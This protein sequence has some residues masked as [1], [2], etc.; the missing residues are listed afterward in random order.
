MLMGFF[1]FLK[2]KKKCDGHEYDKQKD[3]KKMSK[4]L[5]TFNNIAVLQI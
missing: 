2:R 3:N 1:I 5:K 4:Y